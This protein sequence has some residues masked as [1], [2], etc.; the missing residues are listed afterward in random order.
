MKLSAKQIKLYKDI[1]EILWTDWDPIGMKMFDDWPR[2][3]YQSYV[4]II[5][6]LKIKGECVDSIASKLYEMQTET[7][8]ID[9]GYENCKRVAEKIF[10]LDYQ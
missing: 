8:E 10:N 9:G 4:P 7:M 2:D 3:E 6:N 1:D 5:F